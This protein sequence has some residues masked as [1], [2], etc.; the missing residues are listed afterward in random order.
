MKLRALTASLFMTAGLMVSSGSAMA[1]KEIY[2]P[3]VSKGFMHEFWQTV[4]MG[5]DAAAEEL[6]VKTSFVGPSDETQ[7]DQQIQ[8]IENT[9]A[10][11]PNGLLLAALDGNALIPSV[12]RMHAKNVSIV[13]FDSGVN[14]DIPSAFV[15]TNNKKAGAMAAAEVGRLLNGKGKVGIV[16]HVAGTTSAIDR[17]DGFVE[18]MKANY[19]N[20]VLLDPLYSDGDPQ[21]AMN[22]TMD[23]TRANPDLAAVYGTNEGSSM[24][25]A[26]AIQSMGKKDKIK[27]VGFDS[28]EAIVNF[29]ETGVMQAAVVQDAY[30]IG[31]IGLKT[32][33]QVMNGEKVEK[34]IDVPAVLVTG[35]NLRDARIQKVINPLG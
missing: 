6:N 28:S 33:H 19:P 23:I 14:S 24:G 35:D 10:K 25:V 7:I 17:V 9:L 2:L 5:S 1:N 18:H 20:I 26:T 3:V 31:Y 8:L 29:V 11:K 12:N 15:A 16:A 13:T 22:Q 34:L 21:K 30:S 32:L 4:K 27:V